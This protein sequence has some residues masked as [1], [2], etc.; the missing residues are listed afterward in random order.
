VSKAYWL[1]WGA[2]ALAL[3]LILA[4]EFAGAKGVQRSPN[5]RASLAGPI[6]FVLISVVILVSLIIP[7]LEHKN[8]SPTNWTIIAFMYL[9][10]L[11]GIV[12]QF[13]FFQD[14]NGSFEFRPLVKPI[15]A[16]PIVFIPLVSAYQGTGVSNSIF[17]ISDLMIILVSFQNG[18]FWKMIF[19]RQHKPRGRRQ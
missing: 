6:L 10:M 5:G 11:A 9:A 2:S 13:F 8:V 1:I 16:S 14:A 4:T 19:D 18:F 17:T 15:L 3:I 7:S 12:A